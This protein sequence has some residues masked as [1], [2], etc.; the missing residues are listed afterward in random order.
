MTRA[1]IQIAVVLLV[2]RSGALL[3]QLRDAHAPVWPNVW[4]LPGGHVEHGEEVQ[5]AAE[6]ELW[7]ESG[8]RADS[9]LRLFA[10]Q[11]LSDPPRL[12]SYFYGFTRATQ[13]DVILG[14]GAA[15]VFV[16]ADKV[17]AR[18][19]TPGTVQMIRR[20][21]A[22]PEYAGLARVSLSS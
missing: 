10:R 11:K 12:K 1:P 4:C 17:L 8:L 3:L 14:E 21:F 16:P 7:E 22:S 5:A 13:D 9:G 2:D 6:R 20:F 18:E 19:F 15:M